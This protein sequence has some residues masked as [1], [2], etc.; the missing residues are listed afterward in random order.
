MDKKISLYVVNVNGAT[1]TAKY[2]TIATT[3]TSAQSTAVSSSR[4]IIVGS[5][6]HFIAFGTDPIA[7]TSS[8]VLP[9]DTPMQFNFVSGDKIAARTHSGSGYI[10]IVDL[11]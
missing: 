9:A 6:A 10:S 4:I 1:S 5:A 7:T 2:Q 3:T 8:F 11:D